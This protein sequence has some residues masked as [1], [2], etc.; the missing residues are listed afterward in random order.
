M[1]TSENTPS[2]QKIALLIIDVQQGLF[3]RSTPIYKADELLQNIITLVDRAHLSG[4]PVVYVQHSDARNLV[5]GSAA[6]QLHAQ[7]Q[8]LRTDTIIHKRHGNAFEDTPLDETLRAHNVTTVVVTGLVTHGCVKAT[9]IGAQE[10]GFNVILIKDG[11]SSFSKK[12]ADLIEEWNQK[13]SARQIVLRK[14][15]EVTFDNA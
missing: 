6:W 7:L 12:A 8:P 4:V 2:T 15:S 10:S 5:K 1:G 11:H 3:K 14:T 13:L 9:C